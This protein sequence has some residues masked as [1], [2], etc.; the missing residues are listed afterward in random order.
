MSTKV[1]RAGTR[2][3]QGLWEPKQGPEPGL[4]VR[5][6]FLVEVTLELCHEV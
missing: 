3:A 2:E 1:T 6:G 4:R 5:E